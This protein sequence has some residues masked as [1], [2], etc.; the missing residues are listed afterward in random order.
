M[1]GS[2]RAIRRL[3][4]TVGLIGVLAMAMPASALGMTIGASAA[5]RW[6]ACDHD[7]TWYGSVW[8]QLGTQNAG[9]FDYC[10]YLYQIGTVDSAGHVHD[11]DAT[12]DTYIFDQVV[13][14]TTTA[15]NQVTTDNYAKITAA[16]SIAAVGGGYTADPTT[17]SS[18]SCSPFSV[19]GSLG[20]VGIGVSEILCSGNTLRRDS[21]TSSSAQWSSDNIIKTPRWEV[22]YMIKVYQGQKPTFTGRLYYPDYIRYQDGAICGGGYCV[23]AYS[24]TPRWYTDPWSVRAP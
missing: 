12:Y 9:T 2:R 4:A 3:T 16:S 8:H 22:A 18:S 13:D 20:P 21:L 10:A 23:P 11:G 6:W 5:L 14:W 24:S 15:N 19:S 1:P 17:V 7:W